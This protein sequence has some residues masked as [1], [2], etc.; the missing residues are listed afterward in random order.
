MSNISVNSWLNRYKLEGIS[1]LDVK[2][3]RGCKLK[4]ERE[5]DE[6]EILASAKRHWQSLVTAKAEWKFNTGKSVSRDTFRRFF[7]V[8]V[9]DTSELDE[10]TVLQNIMLPGL[11]LSK[12]SEEEVERRAIEKLKMFST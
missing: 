8:L 1:G 11:K 4:I 6:E 12:Y 9:D 10:F 3:G 7:K 5:K 2:S